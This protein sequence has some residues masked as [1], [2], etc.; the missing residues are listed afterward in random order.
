MFFE[1][2]LAER[3]RENEP[4]FPQGDQRGKKEA[5]RSERAKKIAHEKCKTGHVF[6]FETKAREFWKDFDRCPSTFSIVQFI[7]DNSKIEDVL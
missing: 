7:T 1:L 6:E 3:S 4:E 5:R 2:I